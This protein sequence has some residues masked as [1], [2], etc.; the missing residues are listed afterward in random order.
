[1]GAAIRR[2]RPSDT[3]ISLREHEIPVPAGT[4]RITDV[5]VAEII[6]LSADHGQPGSG[7]PANPAG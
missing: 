3:E 6:R 1:M 7:Q 4:D 5:V 2:Q